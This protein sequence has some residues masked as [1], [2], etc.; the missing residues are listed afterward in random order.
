MAWLYSAGLNLGGFNLALLGP[1]LGWVGAKLGLALAWLET[2]SWKSA[3]TTVLDNERAGCE[4]ADTY[5][6]S[7]MVA[8]SNVLLGGNL[9]TL[10]QRDGKV[11]P[12]YG[13][14]GIPSV[15]TRE[16]VHTHPSAKQEVG[17]W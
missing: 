12:L 3:A 7:Q 17:R 4:T 2:G 1:G 11:F 5:D 8:E 13:C 9:G 10:P 16:A 6:N 14:W 15:H